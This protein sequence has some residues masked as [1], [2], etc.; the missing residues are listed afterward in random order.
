MMLTTVYIFNIKK[1]HYLL[2]VSDSFVRST[3]GSLFIGALGAGE[4]KPF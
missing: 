2:G 1:Y 3:V 4:I